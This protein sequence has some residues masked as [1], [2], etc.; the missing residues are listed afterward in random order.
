MKNL[1]TN[2]YAV[3]IDFGTLSAR[4]VL[5]DLETG[6][7]VAEA[8][9][10]YAHGVITALPEGNPL[11]DG[12]ALQHPKDY[13]DALSAC[14]ASLWQTS[15]VS[16]SAVVGL[17]I[18]FTASTLLPV[19]GKGEPL[20]FSTVFKDEPHAYAKLWRH[21]GAT[22]EA[23]DINRCA[24]ARGEAF[25][26]RYGGKISSEF[27]LPKVLETARRAPAVYDA[28]ACFS[29]AGDWLTR[30]LVGKPLQTAVF[31]G[32]K[33]L[34]SE[35]EGFPSAAFLEAL[36]P[37]LSTLFTEKVIT[38]VKS[39]PDIA[40]YLSEEGSALT[41]LP[42]GCAVAL[43]TI[44]A[45][46]ALPAF[47][48][49][50]EGELL[51]ILGTSACHILHAKEERQ[52]GGICG[53]V[54]GL[55]PGL[56]TYEAGQSCFGDHFAWLA[57]NALPDAYRAAAEQEGKSLFAYLN[58]LA[59]QVPV[60][61]DGLLA[62]DWFEG[63][64]SPYDNDALSGL[65]LG[66]RTDT[67]PEA[68]YR[69][70]LEAVAFG[71]RR[72]VDTYKEAGLPISRMVAGGGIAEKNPLLLQILADV[73]NT[74][75]TVPLLPYSSAVGSA[76]YGALAAGAIEDPAAAGRLLSY[77]ERLYTPSENAKAY[78]EIYGEYLSLSHLFAEGEGLSLMQKLQNRRA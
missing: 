70:L 35:K 74:T 41:G 23:E 39:F 64:R 17:G 36:E 43:P 22:K 54:Q 52:I 62:L 65:L 61:A 15:G 78:G 21:H 67:R 56:Y 47:G 40:G 53:Y 37:R 59:E 2:T 51:L 27:F 69:A 5:L 18:D 72:I 28:A 7:I 25:L 77:E 8:L 49:V 38:P 9:S 42:V 24:K 71:T 75:V 63:C 48:I 66:L 19:D 3:G 30:R 12:Y 11:P 60:G 13:L 10:E 76:L 6:S 20:C 45:Y 46:A 4:A 50:G 44:D 33:A 16:P 55:F 29:E 73:L 32:Y 58:T 1:K 34:W 26:S 57:K 31:A 14:F 68:I